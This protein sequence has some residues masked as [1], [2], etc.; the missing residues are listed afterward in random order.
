MRDYF[1]VLWTCHSK[2]CAEWTRLGCPKSIPIELVEAHEAQVWKNHH[3]SSETLAE[4]GGLDPKELLAV[5]TDRDYRKVMAMPMQ[6]AIVGLR[7][8]VVGPSP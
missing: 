2:E 4:R 1:P 5:L 8:L 3:Q 6:D 7:R